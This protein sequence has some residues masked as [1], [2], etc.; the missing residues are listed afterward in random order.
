[1]KRIS[2]LL[3]LT[4]LFAFLL[5]ACGSAGTAT[6]LSPVSTSEPQAGAASQPTPHA[7]SR[8]D[9]LEASNPAS[10]KYGAGRPVL[11][12]FFRFT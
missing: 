1:M 11:V 4:L 5:S 2:Q 10:V 9:K 6:P 3:R 12:E 7:T 8:G